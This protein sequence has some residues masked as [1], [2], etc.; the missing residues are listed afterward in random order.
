MSRNLELFSRQVLDVFMPGVEGLS[1]V[2]S[3]GTWWGVENIPDKDGQVRTQATDIDVVALS[4]LDKKIVIGE[5]KFKNEKVDKNIYDTLVRRG[6]LITAKYK[7]AKYIIFSLSGYTD[8]FLS[9]T[10]ENVLLLT[11]DSL[12][13][14]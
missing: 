3:V 11:L 12:Y 8:W 13:E 2:T 5:C 1:F 10:D 7:L 14:S 4:E 6:K 9:L